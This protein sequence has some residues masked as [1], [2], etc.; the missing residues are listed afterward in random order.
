MKYESNFKTAY[1]YMHVFMIAT[2]SACLRH[3]F[4][5]EIY[6]CFHVYFLSNNLISSE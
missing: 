6:L 4:K 2:F 1:F 3:F 5:Q